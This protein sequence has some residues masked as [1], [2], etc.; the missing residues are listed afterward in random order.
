MD[1]GVVGRLPCLAAAVV[2]GEE[3]EQPTV[4]GRTTTGSAVQEVWVV[5][6]RQPHQQS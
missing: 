4:A 3:D 1:N 2:S 5:D 6:D